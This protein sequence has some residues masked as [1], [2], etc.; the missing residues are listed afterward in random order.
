MID[1]LVAAPL[2]LAA[3]LLLAAKS[4][5]NNRDSLVSATS[6]LGL[7]AALHKPVRWIP[8]IEAALGAGL[9][10]LPWAPA[11]TVVAAVTLGLMLAYTAVIA[12]GLTIKPRPS[13]GCFGTVGAPITADT[14]IRN[15]VLSILGVLAV[16]WGAGGHTVLGAL[17][18]GS[19][20]TWSWLVALAVTAAITRWVVG[21]GQPQWVQAG[22]I[23]TIQHAPAAPPEPA[24][25]DDYLR[26]RIP[27]LMFLEG[28]RPVTLTGLARERAQ[29]LVFITCGCARS[30]DALALARQWREQMTAI[31][32]RAVASVPMTFGLEGFDWPHE[33]LRDP[34]GQ[35]WRSLG[36]GGDPVGLLVGADGM[37]AGGPVTGVAE[38]TEFGEEIAAA[39]AEMP[40]PPQP[41]TDPAAA[42]VRGELA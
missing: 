20:A 14:M 12:R 9:L 4:K 18:Q 7:P 38:L 15:V 32:V 41:E 10:V 28:E 26:E 40:A 36:V 6:L 30:H 39:L 34:D 27:P 33:W 11:F 25:P 37:L 8:P 23:P 29:L 35:A 5:W 42:V 19:R 16:V 24:G 3:V 22:R 13:C 31:D 17:V 21:D 1:A 2:M